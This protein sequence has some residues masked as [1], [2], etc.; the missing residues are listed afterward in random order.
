MLRGGFRMVG[1]ADQSRRVLRHLRMLGD[2]RRLQSAVRMVDTS[3]LERL[4]DVNFVADAIRRAGLVCDE[5]SLYGADNHFMNSGPFGL[6][7][8][9][10][11]LA[12]C[13]IELSKYQIGSMIE[14]GTWSGWTVTFM[15]AF[16]RRFNPWL[17]IL[18]VDT[19][20]CWNLSRRLV[21]PMRVHRGTSRRFE[22]A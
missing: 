4:R 19:S 11:Q 16:L 21:I 20:E 1:L 9:P 2:R 18:T 15:G 14:I 12:R 3:S 6:W 5:R 17:R 13:L 10:A 7:Q 8:I 22:C